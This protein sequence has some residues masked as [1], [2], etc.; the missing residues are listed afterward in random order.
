MVRDLMTR[1]LLTGLN[2]AQVL[3]LL[4][5]PD[6]RNYE[7]DISRSG[8]IVFY[9]KV[10]PATPPNDTPAWTSWSLIVV[11]KNRSGRVAGYGVSKT[12]S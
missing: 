4:G 6:G 9:Y 8:K 11:I 10:A 3:S 1:R 12:S 2:E 5:T 7:P